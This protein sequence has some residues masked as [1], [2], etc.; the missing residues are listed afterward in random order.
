MQNDILITTWHLLVACWCLPYYFLTWWCWVA[1]RG[2]EGYVPIRTHL[3]T[4]ETQRCLAVFPLLPCL[5]LP[6][7]R[8][9]LLLPR[10]DSQAFRLNPA[11]PQLYAV[12]VFTE[13]GPKHLNLDDVIGG[14][15]TW[16]HLWLVCSLGTRRLT[17]NKGIV[18]LL[19]G[20]Y[21]C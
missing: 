13:S 7:N 20:G 14:L 8:R 9:M 2:H 12:I 1:R 3:S 11:L 6:H 17:P 16:E 5:S 15:E 4:A 19:M 10:A 21:E 18:G